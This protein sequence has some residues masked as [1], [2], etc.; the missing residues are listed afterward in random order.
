MN[1]ENAPL[2]SIVL[3][4]YNSEKTI[5][6]C[7]ESI[8]A[9]TFTN[10]ELLVMDAVSKDNTLEII[11]QVQKDLKIQIVSEKDNGIYDAMNKGI[12]LAKGKWIYFL[13]SDDALY[14]SN[15]LEKIARHLQETEGEVVYGNV[16]SERFSGKYAGAFDKKKIFN[17][18]ICHQAVFFKK[19]V[20]EKTGLFDLSYKAHS[21]YDHN[22]KW[23]LSGNVKH[24]FVDIIIAHYAD[25]GFS[26][27]SEDFAFQKIKK[28]KYFFLVR[29]ETAKRIKFKVLISELWLAMKEGRGKDFFLILRQSPKFMLNL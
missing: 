28:W 8:V 18:N 3:P 9:Q 2:I 25:G 29:K 13:G 19:T 1:S 4:T 26:S 22:L 27:Q 5:A 7:M 24:E 14:E 12:A 17:M 11:K 10:F 23:F 15:T 6:R 21:D 16:F 20:F